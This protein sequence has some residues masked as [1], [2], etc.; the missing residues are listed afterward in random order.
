MT[1]RKMNNL[2]KELE[3][4]G[5][6]FEEYDACCAPKQY[7]GNDDI[8]LS[9]GLCPGGEERLTRTQWGQIILMSEKKQIYVALLQDKGTTVYDVCFFEQGIFLTILEAASTVLDS[10]KRNFLYYQEDPKILALASILERCP[11][12][13]LSFSSKTSDVSSIKTA[14]FWFQEYIREQRNVFSSIKDISVYMDDSVSHKQAERL[15]YAL[16]CLKLI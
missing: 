1:R 2:F 10:L 12:E 4:V 8:A 16:D 11:A 14:A 15:Y 6:Y 5:I 7:G 13:I 9:G 3:S